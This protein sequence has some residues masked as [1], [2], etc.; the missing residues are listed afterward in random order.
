M[1]E[2]NQKVKR[3][4][5]GKVVSSKADKTISV[6]IERQ[7][8]HPLYGK[9]IRRSTKLLAHDEENQCNEGDVVTIEECRPLSR[10]KSWKLVSVVEQ[11]QQA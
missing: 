3:S 7:V 10:R 4:V 8:K 9:Y 5:T 11:A 1:A 2:A 6:L